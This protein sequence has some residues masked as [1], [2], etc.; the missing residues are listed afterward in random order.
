MTRQLRPFV[1][2]DCGVDIVRPVRPDRP[3]L[4]LECAVRRSTSNT[5]RRLEYGRSYRAAKARQRIA[6]GGT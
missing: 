4:C 1:C 3:K 5:I 6:A 2:E